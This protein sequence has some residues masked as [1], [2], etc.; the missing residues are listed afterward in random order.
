MD[1]L[2]A[3]HILAGSILTGLAFIIIVITCVVINNIIA[4]Y[5]K[6]IKMFTPDSWKGFHPPEQYP[7]TEKIDPQIE[8]PKK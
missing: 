5:W 4:K 8:T 6:P 1:V 3:S 2:V 7:A